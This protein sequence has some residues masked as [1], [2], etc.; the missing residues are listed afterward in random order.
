MSADRDK[1]IAAV[2]SVSMSPQYFD[3][4]LDT[5]DALLFAELPEDTERQLLP[6]G[7]VSGINGWSKPIEY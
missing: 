1:L 7:G 3:E 6:G 5:I 4:S 2:Y